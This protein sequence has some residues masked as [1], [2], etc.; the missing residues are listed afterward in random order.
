MAKMIIDDVMGYM[1][2]GQ[3]L[4]PG[5]TIRRYDE[6]AGAWFEGKLGNVSSWHHEKQQRIS[7][8]SLV[9]EGYVPSPLQVGDTIEIIGKA[10]LYNREIDERN[11]IAAENRE[12]PWLPLYD[13]E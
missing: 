4:E 5:M 6:I 10:E 1:V 2:D 12:K 7:V 11:R 8:L 13:G 9:V 3:R